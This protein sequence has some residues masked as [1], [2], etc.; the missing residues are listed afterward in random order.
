MFYATIDCGTTNS[1]A[2]IVDGKGKIYGKSTMKIGVK[3][4][5]ETGSKEP[6]RE[7]VRQIIKE[8]LASAGMKAADLQAV[9]S[10]GMITSEIG[11]VEIPHLSAPCGLEELAGNIVK[12]T[13]TEIIEADIPVYFVPGIKNAIKDTQRAATQMVGE[14]DFMRGEEVQLIGLMSEY[15]VKLPV[16]VVMLSSHTKFMSID[17]SGCVLGSLTT[18]SGQLY[19]AMLDHTF[20]GKS[21]NKGPE[22]EPS[23]KDYYDENIVSDAIMWIQK[24]GLLRSVLFPRFLDVLLDTKWYERHLFFDALIAAEDMLSIGQ[25]EMLGADES[26]NYILIG[27]EARC[28]L[29]RHI[30]SQLFPQANISCISGVDEIDV[31]SIKGILAVA[32]KAGIIT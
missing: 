23:P 27:N 19:E 22:D 31:L 15:G 13:D 1:R 25:L 4:T 32:R 16:T 9:L 30:L 14:L 29:Y 2:Y 5:A 18:M 26:L 8:A 28:N 21:V 6:L 17:K 7:G 11:L 10:S 3:D 20:L 12:T 24:V